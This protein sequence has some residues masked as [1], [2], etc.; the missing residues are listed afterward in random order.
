MELEF[1]SKMDKLKSEYEAEKK[2]KSTLDKELA[3]AKHELDNI[4]INFPK[5]QNDLKEQ[6]EFAKQKT[7]DYE[8]NTKDLQA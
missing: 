1:E 3:D 8:K 5:E 7:Y 2:K 4:E 6:I